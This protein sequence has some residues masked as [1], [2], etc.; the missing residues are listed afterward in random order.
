MHDQWHQ[1]HLHVDGKDLEPVGVRVEK[2]EDGYLERLLNPP[3]E[4]SSGQVG[5]A[6]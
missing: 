2:T 4:L 1:A 5:L 3:Q 6:L